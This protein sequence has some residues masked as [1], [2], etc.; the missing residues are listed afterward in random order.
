MPQGHIGSRTTRKLRLYFSSE[1]GMQYVTSTV[2][3]YLPCSFTATGRVSCIGILSML[4]SCACSSADLTLQPFQKFK[5]KFIKFQRVSDAKVFNSEA[6]LASNENCVYC[7]CLMS[8][9]LL[10]SCDPWN[11]VPWFMPLFWSAKRSCQLSIS[12]R[13]SKLPASPPSVPL[14]RRCEFQASESRK[15]MKVT[16]MK[17]LYWFICIFI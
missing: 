8:L 11:T 4:L 15:S 17:I 14:R 5:S 6:F 13:F 16:E 9:L 7:S 10:W 12:L 1:L 2:S 3:M